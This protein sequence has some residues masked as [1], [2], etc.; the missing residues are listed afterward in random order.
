MTRLEKFV[1][2]VRTVGLVGFFRDLVRSIVQHE[3]TMHKHFFLRRGRARSSRRRCL[4]AFEV[5][6]A[7]FADV[8]LCRSTAVRARSAARRWSRPEALGHSN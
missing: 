2:F 4:E 6:L 8:W 5:D 3:K 7:R 1:A